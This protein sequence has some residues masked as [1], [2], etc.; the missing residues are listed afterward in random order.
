[1]KKMGIIRAMTFVV[2][3]L[4]LVVTNSCVNQEYELSEDRLNLEMTV[5]QDGLSVPLGSTS[6][7]M[8]KDVKDSLLAGLEDTTF[9][10]YFTVGANGEYGAA[11][12]DRLDLSDTLNNLLAQ[13]E[14]PDVPFSET[15][16]FN[17]NSVDVSSLTVPESVYEYTE[18][19]GGKISAPDFSFSGFGTDFEVSAELYKYKPSED[20][21]KLDI[22][23][24][25]RSAELAGL[26]NN[27]DNLPEDMLNDEPLPLEELLENPLFPLDMRTSYGPLTSEVSFSIPLPKGITSV[28]DIVLND[29][30]RLKLSIELTNS[31]FTEGKITPSL[32]LDL[33]EIFHLA[34]SDEDIIHAEFAIDADGRTPVE[35]EFYIE[36]LVI[37]DEDWDLVDGCLTLTKDITLTMKGDISHNGIVTTTNHLKN[38]GTQK[39]G[40]NFEL[41]FID[42]QVEDVK[43]TVEP[44][45]MDVPR[46]VVSFSQELS[47]PEQ[48][49]GIDYVTLSDDSKISMSIE[50]ANMLEGLEL[51]MASLVLTFPEGI[52]VEG[53]QNGVVTYEDVDLSKGFSSHV[54]IKGITLPAPV[55]GEIILNKEVSVEAV[56]KAGGTISSA[57]LP[58][59][60]DKDLS[61]KVNVEADF[62]I[63]DYSV[64]VTGYDYPVEYSQDFKFDVT[65]L[66]EFGTVSVIPQGEP[67]IVIEVEMPDIDLQIVADPEDNLVIAFPKMLQFGSLPQEYNYDRNTGTLTFKGQIP[68][69]IVLP[70]DRLVITPEEEDGKYWAK[71]EFKV[72]GGIA[73]EGGSIDKDDVDALTDPACQVGMSA[74]IPEIVMET[75]AMDQAYEKRIEKS[76]EI[77]MLSSDQLPEQLVSIESIELEDVYFNL[78]LDASELPD[79]GSTK[80]SLEFD[81]DLPEMI[82]LDPDN[83]KEGNV[84]TVKGELD[85]DGIIAIDPVKIVGLDLS[86]IDLKEL[87]D[88]KETVTIDG[89]VVL[90]D[91][92]LDVNDWLG[93]NL[94]VKVEGGIKDIAISKVTGK[95]DFH[96][97]P[98]GASVDLS[99]VRD[100]LD[101]GNLEITGVENLL[102]RL[103]LSADIKTN[104]GIP[105]GAKMLVTPYSG[106]NPVEDAVWETEITLNHSQ[107]ADEV[108]HTRYW[109]SSLEESKDIYRPEGFTHIHLPLQQYLSDIP[110]SLSISIEAGTD[111][112]QRCIIEPTQKYVVEAEY[113]AHIPFEFGDGCNVTYRDTIPDLPEL[114]GQLLAMGDL[115]L[116]GDITSSLPLSIGL[117]VNLLDSDGNK[118]PLD[119][120]AATQEIKGCGPD[121]EPVVTELYLGIQKEEGTEFKD[122]N[123]I[124]LE[125]NLATIGGVPLSDNCFLQASLQALV[126]NGVNVDVNEFIDENEQ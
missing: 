58:S 108:M 61:V 119:E 57:D 12:S 107:S 9:L 17:L 49:K 92:A 94:E 42:F 22:P 71:G 16:S 38:Q 82:R 65:G 112:E 118:V 47:L 7:I 75:L 13:I 25:S 105:M 6:R 26:D 81:I 56:V 3:S 122:V 91:I 86:T 20:I 117:K 74:T 52:E 43:M 34:S 96:V 114:V 51:E 36:S 50:P 8:L 87:E 72:S 76:F 106:G 70:V 123:A 109:I 1:M 83:V 80:L 125:F 84:L 98:I 101:Q 14:I 78:S 32:T 95:V 39:M 46:K 15:F 88:F 23:E 5:F 28:E 113:S 11:I 33:R 111:P 48:I 29:N 69:R 79:L 73:L 104:I 110:D 59:T 10:N 2:A 45:S 60:K 40:I 41:E 85:E 19:I 97:D 66:E 4:L 27:L 18:K 68:P 30:A 102:S 120:A 99:S 89:K 31:L 53:A 64:E 24:I 21:L 37:S 63:E 126:P 90:D 67:E 35:K 124:E 121:G 103:T 55:N 115:V 100:L 44:I 62:A 93:K 116:T 54:R 77:G